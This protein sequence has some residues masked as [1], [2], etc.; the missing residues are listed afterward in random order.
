M[1][2]TE[3]IFIFLIKQV[4]E[5]NIFTKK[6]KNLLKKNSYKIKLKP[7]FSLTY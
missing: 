6:N 7:Y 3:I 2:I 1:I 5:K 4:P